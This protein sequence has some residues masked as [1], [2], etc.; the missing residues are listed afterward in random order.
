MA[1]L[2]SVLVVLFALGLVGLIVWAFI[3]FFIAITRAPSRPV[4]RSSSSSAPAGDELD[5]MNDGDY[6]NGP[7]GYHATGGYE[8]SFYG[9]IYDH[10]D[11]D[12]HQ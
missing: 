2:G 5:G 8:N 11:D 10:D 12:E 1:I 7:G 6:Y 3:A 4:T 9:Q